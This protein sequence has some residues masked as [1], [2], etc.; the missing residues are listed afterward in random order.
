MAEEVESHAIKVVVR[1]RPPPSSEVAE[2]ER[3]G[4]AYA[5]T[6][7]ITGAD[8]VEAS[9][10]ALN[11]LSPSFSK[12]SDTVFQCRFTRVL[13][14]EA[15]QEDVFALFRADVAAVLQVRSLSSVPPRRTT[16]TC[17]SGPGRR[18]PGVVGAHRCSWW[19]LCL[20]LLA[21]ANAM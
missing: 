4:H 15:T 7:A 8:S 16:C 2:V 5:G 17:A 21:L 19:L 12:G 10:P 13:P 1:V 3:A 18:R 6:L 9:L 11:V 20:F 14:P